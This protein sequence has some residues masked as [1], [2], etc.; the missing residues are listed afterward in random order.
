MG[1]ARV[2]FDHPGSFVPVVQH[3]ID[4]DHTPQLHPGHQGRDDPVDI[5]PID[6]DIQRAGSALL[7]KEVLADIQEGTFDL[8]EAVDI[9]VSRQHL[10]A[11]GNAFLQDRGLQINSLLPDIAFHLVRRTESM[12]TARAKGTGRF[13]DGRENESLLDGIGH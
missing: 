8:A 3:Q 6:Q 5:F 11:E 12:K 1:G 4:A 7:G 10:T 13:D 9:D 2:D